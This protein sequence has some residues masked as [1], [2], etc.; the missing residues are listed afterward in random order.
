MSSLLYGGKSVGNMLIAY[1]KFIA[2]V[3]EVNMAFPTTPGSA[4]IIVPA[5]VIEADSPENVALLL[6]FTDR[7]RWVLLIAFLEGEPLVLAS[8][9]VIE[10]TT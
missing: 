8:R 3:V 4:P 7:R 5:G 9:E 10:S 1:Y 6:C 2:T